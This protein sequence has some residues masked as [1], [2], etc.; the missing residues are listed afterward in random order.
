[1]IAKKRRRKFGSP[2]YIFNDLL[3]LL[4]NFLSSFPWLNLGSIFFKSYSFLKYHYL[5]F[6]ILNH[7]GSMIQNK[8][9]C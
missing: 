9:R 7:T 5:L 3:V 6:L 8:K 4:H 1:M 2:D